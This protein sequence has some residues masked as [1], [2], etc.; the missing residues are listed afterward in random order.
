MIRSNEYSHNSRT[1]NCIFPKEGNRQEMSMLTLM[2]TLSHATPFGDG[3]GNAFVEIHQLGLSL[4]SGFCFLVLLL[5]LPVLFFP[6]YGWRKFQINIRFH[7]QGTGFASFFFLLLLVAFWYIMLGCWEKKDLIFCS[8]KFYW[9]RSNTEV[10]WIHL[11]GP[12]I[13]SGVKL[14]WLS[15]KVLGF[16]SDLRFSF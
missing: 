11:V 6:N 12:L 16:Y 9:F 3:R 8:N 7:S 4:R 2:T 15:G 10:M 13:H 1:L 5:R 14:G